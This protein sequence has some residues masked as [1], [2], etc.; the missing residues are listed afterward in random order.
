MTE[1]HR[2]PYDDGMFRKETT[3]MKKEY[4]SDV[5]FDLTNESD[6]LETDLQDIYTGRDSVTFSIKTERCS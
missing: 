6:A 2:R 4:F 1:K 5:L 3:A